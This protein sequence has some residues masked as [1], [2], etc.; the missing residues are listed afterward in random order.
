[1]SRTYEEVTGKTKEEASK[2][3]QLSPDTVKLPYNSQALLLERLQYQYHW[4]SLS[5]RGE[6]RGTV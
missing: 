4:L 5:Q 1:M 6:L 2:L 3:L